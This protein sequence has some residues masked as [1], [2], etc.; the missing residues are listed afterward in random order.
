[1]KLKNIIASV[2]IA[3]CLVSV[4]CKPK[5]KDIAVE[6][7]K[8]V[9]SGA[10][11]AV[12]DGV[13][14]LTG[15]FSDEASK[16][17]AE[18]ALAKVKDVKSVVNNATVIAPP[19]PP[20][21]APVVTAADEVLTKGLKDATKDYPTVTATVKDGIVTLNGDIKKTNMVKL[22]MAINALQPKKIENKLTIK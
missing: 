17:A 8:V 11:V 15:E 14:T 4:G 21:A 9:P 18:E 3:T 22:M 10:L 13:A 6:A 16:K 1:M 5:D 19:P 12:K 20:A 2:A 7:Q